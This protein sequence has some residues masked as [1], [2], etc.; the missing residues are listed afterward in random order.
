MPAKKQIMLMRI[1]TKLGLRATLLLTAIWSFSTNA[2]AYDFE[3]DGICYRITSNNTV[4]MSCI[5]PDD[6]YG[7][8]YETYDIVV[9]EKVNYNGITYT[10][11][12]IGGD[13]TEGIGPVK[14]ISLP[15]TIIIIEDNAFFN[16]I[17]MES[18]TIPNSVTTI[19]SEVFGFYERGVQNIY[20][21]G[22]PVSSL[23]SVVIGKSV[24]T[25][26]RGSFYTGSSYI[27]DD[28]IE[29]LKEIYCLANVP[30]QTDV[31]TFQ[32]YGYNY[33]G[34]RWNCGEEQ[35]G[36]AFSGIY[37]IV[38]NFGGNF[39]FENYIDYRIYEEATLYVPRESV[40]DYK[41]APEWC[42]FKHIV[43]IDV[44]ADIPEDVNGDGSVN[45]TDVNKLIEVIISTKYETDLTIYDVNGDGAVNI[46]DVNQVVHHILRQ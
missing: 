4:A 34:D 26:G 40:N 38:D 37:E 24:K 21:Y 30:P 46:S 17:D 1:K 7:G 31:Y 32:P 8:Y 9:P 41:N 3:V 19:G 20:G 16:C 44:P 13:D 10:V 35:T 45:I 42:M 36:G 22:Y 12:S 18:I 39:N 25:I 11:T 23:R 33:S 6:E 14:S 29:C 15:N 43:G 28:A 5:T 27:G 2:V